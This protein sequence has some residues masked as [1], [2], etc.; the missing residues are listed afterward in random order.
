MPHCLFIGRRWRRAGLAWDIGHLAFLAAFVGFGLV[1]MALVQIAASLGGVRRALARAAGVLGG[2]GI[3]LFGWVIVGDLWP[4]VEQAYELPDPV[5]A[6]G[7]LRFL[8]GLAVP[9]GLLAWT[10]PR[11]APPLAPVAVAAAFVLL[12]LDLRLLAAA[13]ALFGYGL[14]SVPELY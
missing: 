1:V 5:M 6:V 3:L 7:P 13:G 4:E 8:I 11:Q 9:L 14:W 2:V 10:A 12:A